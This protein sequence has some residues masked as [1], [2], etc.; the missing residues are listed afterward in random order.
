M[1]STRVDVYT[2]ASSSSCTSSYITRVVA[3]QAG[4]Q[5]ARDPRRGDA[6]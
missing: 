2:L 4:R 3:L 1:H 5:I 6:D